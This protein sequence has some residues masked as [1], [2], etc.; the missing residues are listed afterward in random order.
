MMSHAASGKRPWCAD[1]S[2][3][4]PKI[5]DASVMRIGAR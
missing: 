3:T 5:I 4:S 2:D 1:H